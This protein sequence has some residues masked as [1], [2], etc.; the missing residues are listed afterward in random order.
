MADLAAERKVHV[1][2]LRACAR[3]CGIALVRDDAGQGRV[4]DFVAAIA[5]SRGPA[6]EKAKAREA[7]RAY[8]ATW[9][10]TGVALP[11]A[12]QAP[13]NIGGGHVRLRG[14]SFML[15]YNWDFFHTPFPDGNRSS[16]ECCRRVAMRAVLEG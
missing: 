15:T 10:P 16:N 11:L 13:A 9:P 4:R 7:Y 14:T 5:G 2:A 1:Q 12:P 3:A 8:A 6:R